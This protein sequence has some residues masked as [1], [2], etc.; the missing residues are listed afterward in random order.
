LYV[1]PVIDSTGFAYFRH[2][3]WLGSSRLA[4]QWDHTIYTKEAYAPFGEPYNESDRHDRSFTG[5]DQDTVGTGTGLYDFLYR[6]Y[7]PV[8]GRWISPDPA[9]LGAVDPSNPQ[10]WNRYAYVVNNPMMMIDPLG[11]DGCT[12]AGWLPPGATPCDEKPIS[13][14][15]NYGDSGCHTVPQ[16]LTVTPDDPNPNYDASNHDPTC[17]VGY[18]CITVPTGPTG[19][20]GGGGGG[21]GTTGG[22]GPAANNG[23][24]QP[25]QTS[26]RLTRLKNCAL[27]YY[28]IDPLSATGLA[29]DA[30]KW[31][32][33]GGPG[34]P[35]A[36]AEAV[37]VRVIR[38]AGDSSFT[39]LARIGSILS[40]GAIQPVAVF[41]KRFGGPIAIASAVIDATAIGI[42]TA[43]D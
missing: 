11:L 24:Q 12:Y 43:M 3:D 34:V 38:T 19:P 15:A 9:G 6:R 31:L 7:H 39:S 21:G 41:A 8:Q 25:S 10:T 5:Q 32:L 4:T 36:A 16:Y 17:P 28:G 13:V 37:G 1:V 29:S 23:T 26:E 33:A 42:C 20:N 14:P 27:A 35:K 18:V 40:G 30:S 2:S 22:S